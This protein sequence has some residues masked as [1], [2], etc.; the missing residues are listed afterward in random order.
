ML[1]PVSIG[2]FASISPL[3]H[4]Q[5]ARYLATPCPEVVA[6]VPHTDAK[7]LDNG[8]TM[9]H[10]HPATLPRPTNRRSVWYTQIT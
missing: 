3:K 2:G 5:I 9:L 4:P 1:K 10:R 8:V 6:L 7:S